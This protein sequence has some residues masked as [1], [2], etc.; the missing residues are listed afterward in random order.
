MIRERNQSVCFVSWFARQC[1][2]RMNRLFL[3]DT[4]SKITAIEFP[5]CNERSDDR[6]RR[7]TI[8]TWFGDDVDRI[9]MAANPTRFVLCL[10]TLGGSS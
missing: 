10:S 7:T 2:E 3:L 9:M 1:S 6:N 8:L 4:A 5:S